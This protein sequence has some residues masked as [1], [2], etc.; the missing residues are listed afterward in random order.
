M[1]RSLRPERLAMTD[2][3]APAAEFDAIARL[4]AGLLD[5]PV[6]T[7][8][9]FGERVMRVGGCGVSWPASDEAAFLRWI[10]SAETADAHPPAVLDLASGDVAGTDSLIADGVRGAV[11][12][13]LRGTGEPLGVL[14]VYS[15]A[16]LEPS[17]A[18]R[19]RLN[20]LAEVATQ[21]LLARST[22]QIATT[23]ARAASQVS[24]DAEAVAPE[25]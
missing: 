12:A 8:T 17:H 6:A 18:A 25:A 13:P 9:A 19:R 23:E 22:A 1:G 3:L 7:V 21:L 14:A 15:P 11:A 20:D 2:R 5:A 24:E 4:A 16:V 10:A